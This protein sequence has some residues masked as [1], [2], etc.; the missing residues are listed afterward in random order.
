MPVLPVSGL[1]QTDYMVERQELLLGLSAKRWSLVFPTS[2]ARLSACHARRQ[3]EQSINT[4]DEWDLESPREFWDM[5]THNGRVTARQQR[6][7]SRFISFLNI[8]LVN[9][10]PDLLFSFFWFSFS[11]SCIFNGCC[12]L[13]PCALLPHHLVRCL[14]DT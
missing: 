8:P 1:H 5:Y 6:I 12:W 10:R 9:W 3:Y 7:L 11:R 13:V 2:L 14:R 4:I